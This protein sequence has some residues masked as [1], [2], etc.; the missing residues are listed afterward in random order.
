MKLK[1]GQT[2]VVLKFLLPTQKISM[3]SLS[4]S[5]HLHWKV[6]WMGLS[7]AVWRLRGVVH[8]FQTEPCGNVGTPERSCL[9]S[10]RYLDFKNPNRIGKCSFPVYSILKKAATKSEYCTKYCT[11]SLEYISDYSEL[12]ST[13]TIN[14]CST[15]FKGTFLKNADNPNG[16]CQIHSTWED[17][18]S[19]A[20]IFKILL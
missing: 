9:D 14:K 17:Q 1:W 5:Y 10:G 16:I 15:F 13:M 4:Y 3:K 6:L 20:W 18:C 7:K 8:W 11:V 19:W 12:Q 2:P